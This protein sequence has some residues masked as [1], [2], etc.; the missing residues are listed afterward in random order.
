MNKEKENLDNMQNG[1]DF[2]ADVGKSLLDEYPNFE[3]AYSVR[4]LHKDL[5]NPI[6]KCNGGYCYARNKNGDIIRP[7]E[8]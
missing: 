4:K 7:C 2:I 1:N 5:K 3:Q 8:L 6:C